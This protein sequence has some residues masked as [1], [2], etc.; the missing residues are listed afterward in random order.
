VP[1][2]A[3][4]VIAGLFAGVLFLA[5]NVA[6]LHD[7]QPHGVPIAISGAPESALPLPA[8]YT[9]SRVGDVEAAVRRR[10]AYGGLDVARGQIVVA[11]ANGF[12]ASMT[13]EQ[14]LTKAAPKAGVTRPRTVDAVP[15]QPGD[16]RGLSLQQIVLGTI[17]GGFMMGV[18]TAQLAL[19]EPLW[20]RGLAYAGFGA[21]FGL[22]GAL[23]LD[24]LL[25]VLTGHFA[26]LW[27]C[28]GV[29]ALA[30]ALSVGALARLLGQYGLPLALV[31]FL[32]VGNPSAGA[33][34]PTEFLPGFYRAVGPWLPPNA[35]TRVLLGSTY[36]DAA[37]LGPALVLAAWVIVPAAVLVAVDR[38]HGSRRALAHDAAGAAADRAD[39]E[40]AAI[41]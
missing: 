15:L 29:T 40:P 4:G 11:S 2:A 18:L 31:T 3:L 24:P 36:F 32:I 7:P 19:G 12:Q 22:L 41:G 13:I 27:A 37:V 26:A 10:E 20:Q 17:I 39:R 30:I 25:G 34:S 28:I 21:L 33:S 16:P 38:R 6:A 9:V 5:S 23:V 35:D 1:R 14:V 8:G